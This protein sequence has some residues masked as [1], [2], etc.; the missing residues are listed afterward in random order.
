[1]VPTGRIERTIYLIR[2]QRVMLDSN[3]AELYGVSAKRLNEQVKRNLARF[4]ADF[5]FQLTREEAAA[6]RSQIAT[7]HTGRGA[8]RKYLPY[9]FTELGVAMLSSVLRSDRAIKVNIAIMRAFARL[10]EVLATHKD[11]ARKLAE[12]EKTLGEHD[13]KFQVVF[14]AIRQLMHPPAPRKRRRIGF[15]LK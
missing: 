10:R 5:M 9:A 1:M 8:H 6:I 13:E 14:E 7:I 11:F 4:P 12:L 2:D 3:L 15:R